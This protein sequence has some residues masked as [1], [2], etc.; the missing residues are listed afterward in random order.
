MKF[1]I[2]KGLRILDLGCGTG[3]LLSAL[4]PE[5]GVGVDFSPLMIENAQKKYPHYQFILG[6][7]ENPEIISQLPGPFDIVIMSDTIG[8]LDDC[9]TCL[10]R[11]HILCN[12]DTRII[13]SYY[14]SFWEPLLTIAEKC[15]LKSPQSDLNWLSSD[16]ISNILFLTDFE[17]VKQD[18]HQ[19]V[20]RR[21]LG[22]G[23]V[24]NRFIAPLPLIRKLCIRNYVVARSI[25][26]PEKKEYSTTI[27]IPC[28]NEKGNIENAI[29]R[30]PPFCPD[31]EIIFVEGHSKDGTLSEIHRVMNCYKTHDI[32]VLVQ[33]GIGKA[34]AVRMGFSVAR[35]EILMILDADLTTPP[36]DLPKFYHAITH[37]KGEFINGSRLVYPLENDS[38]RFLNRIANK[39]FS[40]AFS[41]L[42]NQRYTDTLCGTKVLKKKHY[43]IIESNRNYFGDLDPFGDYDLIFGASKQNMKVTEVPIRYASRRY[44]I[45]QISR[46]SHGWLLVKMVVFAY[47][48]LKAF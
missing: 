46:L 25:K 20:P 28:R 6:D 30:I 13:I 48:K 32:K 24:V 21:I 8:Q 39:I 44:G 22:L 33:P 41:Y 37:N 36:E 42:L 1:L 10:E 11:L 40:W 34:D 47:R 16:D 23:H 26:N 15:H 19:L 17:T 5:F 2:P 12:D 7:V 29:K 3:D 14:N 43:Q 31:I 38:M 4:E 35:G 9:Q 27:I 18:W 45:S